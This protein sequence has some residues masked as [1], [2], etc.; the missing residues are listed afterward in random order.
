MCGCVADLAIGETRAEWAVFS[1]TLS[2]VR[3]APLATFDEKMA[4]INGQGR[5]L[6]AKAGAQ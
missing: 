2:L 6:L 4:Q 3:M 5:C 1:G